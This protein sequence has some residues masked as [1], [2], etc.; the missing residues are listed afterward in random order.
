MGTLV[1]GLPYYF[2]RLID[3]GKSAEVDPPQSIVRI[4]FYSEILGPQMGYVSH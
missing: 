4:L 3:K 1:R 2:Q